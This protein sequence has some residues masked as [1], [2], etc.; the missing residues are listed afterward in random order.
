MGIGLAISRMLVE[1]NK[2]LPDTVYDDVVRQIVET[3][4][5]QTVRRMI[6]A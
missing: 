1:L 5:T 3:S 4:S 6:F 2:G